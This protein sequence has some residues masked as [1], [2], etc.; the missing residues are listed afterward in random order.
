MIFILGLWCLTPLSIIFQLYRGGQ[1]YWWRK[2]S[3]WR[4]LQT[5][6]KAVNLDIGLDLFIFCRKSVRP[7]SLSFVFELFLIDLF[8]IFESDISALSNLNSED[9]FAKF[10]SGLLPTRSCLVEDGVVIGNLPGMC[11]GVDFIGT[12]PG[13]C[14]GVDLIGTLLGVPI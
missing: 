6:R 10:L 12:L 11:S 3:T 8:L 9:L 14:S 5:C 1:F 2:K 13:V 7:L 4:N